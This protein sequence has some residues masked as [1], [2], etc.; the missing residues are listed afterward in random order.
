L[1]E[2][3]SE[4]V[5][6]VAPLVAYVPEANASG[7]RWGRGD[8][9]VTTLP[10]L[11]V[12]AVRAPARDTVVR[13]STVAPDS[14]GRDW[15]LVV[16]RTPSAAVV[17]AAGILGGRTSVR[18]GDSQLTEYVISTALHDGLAGAGLFDL[19]GRTLG[20]IVRCGG[21]LVATPMR[22]VARLLA[23]TVSVATRLWGVVGFAAEP[24]TDDARAYFKSDSGLL[25]T[26]IRRGAIADALALRPGDVL[27]AIDGRP[28]TIPRDLAP[29]ADTGQPTHSVS[30]RR[31]DAVTTVEV[32]RADSV[33]GRQGGAVPVSDLGIDIGA[34]VAPR[35]VAID[36]VRT[37]SAAAAA[38]L[39]AGD[40]LVRV[41][42]RDV[43]SA[44]P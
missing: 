23:D 44:T 15:V 18:C 13:S 41:D 34:P 11:P 2:F 19:S 27:L 36:H 39:R 24:L 43:T 5:A 8:S 9:L 7:V 29:L 21:R 16:G 32:P 4:R 3:L 10:A 31:G 26:A 38:G 33:S 6:A 35:G 42:T 28:V 14:G 20:L 22:D 40:R 30:R 25:V 37:G 17:S 1:S 12:V